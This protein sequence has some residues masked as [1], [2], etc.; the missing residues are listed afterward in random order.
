MPIKRGRTK[1]TEKKLIKN[2]NQR[3]MLKVKNYG[4]KFKL[5][6]IENEV[7][8]YIKYKEKI[9]K[10]FKSKSIKTTMNRLYKLNEIRCN[11]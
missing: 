9:S 6:Q 1:K 4:N 7:K 5:K 10:I 11:A 3:K 8:K 2:Q